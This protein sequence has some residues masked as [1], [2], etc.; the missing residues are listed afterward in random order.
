MKKTIFIT[1]RF[2]LNEAKIQNT[3]NFIGMSDDELNA[4]FNDKIQK[5]KADISTTDVTVDPILRR[6]ENY[7]SH[8][9]KGIS[10]T[11]KYVG[12][13]VTTFDFTFD[14]NNVELT[15]ENKTNDPSEIY[16]VFTQNDP[17]TKIE[18]NKVI[19]IEELPQYDNINGSK[20]E[21]EKKGI[22]GR[23]INI[24]QSLGGPAHIKGIREIA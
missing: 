24:I 3:T 22:F 10:F 21:K 5:D 4:Q 12:P 18:E 8:H 19:C 1:P 23:C 7:L 17:W 20:E 6:I 15:I 2:Y 11:A 16:F 13:K 9:I 14:A